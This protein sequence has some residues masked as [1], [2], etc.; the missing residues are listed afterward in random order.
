M[1]K[2]HLLAMA[3]SGLFALPSFAGEI[4]TTTPPPVVEEE[5]SIISGSVTLGFDS[6]YVYRGNEI[7]GNNGQKA[8][9]LV[10]A[11]LDV[12]AA[13]TDSLSANFNAWYASSAVGNYDEL[14]LYTRLDYS[15]GPFTIGPSFRWYYY[16]EVASAFDNQYEVGLELGL[17][18][19]ENLS[20]SLGSF[21]EFETKGWYFQFDANYSIKISDRFA[22]VPGASVSFVDVHSTSWGLTESDFHHVTTYLKAEISLLKNVTLAPYIAVNFPLSSA[23]EAAQDNL[24]YGGATF[25]VSF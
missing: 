11:G 5:S 17:S 8:R 2:T 22:L 9:R 16:P 13:L 25:S 18:P 1:K 14:N 12:N 7:P 4:V 24:V 20:L 15:V 10:H 21:Y 3:A 19:V 6:D 23:L